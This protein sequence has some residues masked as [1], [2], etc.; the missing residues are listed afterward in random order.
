[1]KG[2]LYLFGM[3]DEMISETDEEGGK[4]KVG[5]RRE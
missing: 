2:C 1:M 5:K 3:S 4:V